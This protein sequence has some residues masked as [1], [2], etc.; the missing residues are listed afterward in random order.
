MTPREQEKAPRARRWSV[1]NEMAAV[2]R[3]SE[4]ARDEVLLHLLKRG[5]ASR[6]EMADDL[7]ARCESKEVVKRG[8][9]YLGRRD[10]IEQTGAKGLPWRLTEAG[11]AKAVEFQAARARRPA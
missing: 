4:I 7:A 2:R 9:A 1:T 5:E 6:E 10:E 8:I 11:R 3:A